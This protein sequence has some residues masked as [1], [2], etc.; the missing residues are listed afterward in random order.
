MENRLLVVRCL[1][2]SLVGRKI[3]GSTKSSIRCLHDDRKVLYVYCCSATSIFTSL[4]LLCS[5]CFLKKKNINWIIS[6]QECILIIKGDIIPVPPSSTEVEF[7]MDKFYKFSC[8]S[9]LLMKHYHFGGLC[10]NNYIRKNRKETEKPFPFFF[11][12]FCL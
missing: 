4:K 10:E 12:P 1:R 2:G 3:G 9:C 7:L 8:F 11:Y 6:V 5:R